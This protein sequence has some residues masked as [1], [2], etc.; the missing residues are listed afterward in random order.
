MVILAGAS[1][2]LVWLTHAGLDTIDFRPEWWVTVPSFAG[3]YSGLHWLFD[4]HI[5]KSRT[6]GRLGVVQIPDLNGL[7]TGSVRSSIDNYTSAYEV[8]V[9]IRQHWSRLTVRL[10]TEHSQSRSLG[11]TFRI[12]DLPYPEL[13]YLYIN[14]PKAGSHVSMNSHRGTVVLEFKETVLEGQYYTGRGRM[15][16]GT[17]HLTRNLGDPVD[18]RTFT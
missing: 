9:V 2:L 5:W 10:E 17:I 3:F 18:D 13:S 4:R 12:G 11:A 15:T 8:K 6:L 7:W 1:F 16:N 14:E